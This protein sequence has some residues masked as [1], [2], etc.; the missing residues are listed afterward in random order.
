MTTSQTLPPPPPDDSPQR[1]D[2]LRDEALTLLESLA[3]DEWTDFN[4]HDPG[5]TILEALCYAITDLAY[6]ASFPIPD[7]LAR[8]GEPPP[9]TLFTPAQIL[10]THP[11]TLSDWRRLVI[12]M[13]GVKNAWVERTPSEIDLYYDDLDGG[14]IVTGGAQGLRPI[15]IQGLYRIVYERYENRVA[16]QV[17]EHVRER[18][19]AHRGLCEDFT[20][21]T[22]LTPQNIAVNVSVEIDAVDDPARVLADIYTALTREMSPAVPVHTLRERQQAEVPTDKI[23]EG[24]RPQNSFT[25]A[26]TVHTSTQ[27]ASVRVSDLVRAIMSVD[28]VRIVRTLRVGGLRDTEW[29][30][31][32]GENNV[33]RLDIAQSEIELVRAGVPVRLDPDTMT[34]AR[35]RYQAQIRESQPDS[36][37][38]MPLE[39]GRDRR[40]ATYRSIQHDLPDIYGLGG[41]P[42][43]TPPE[44]QAQM[45]QLQAYLLLF[46]LVLSSSQAQ[47]AH[48]RDLLDANDDPRTTFV[49]L[50]TDPNLLG[51]LTEDPADVLA[52]LPN[53]QTG[54]RNH[55]LDHMLAR[56]AEQ[57]TDYTLTS[58][59]ETS[60]TKADFLRQY[61]QIS[62]ARGSGYNYLQPA[63]GTNRSGLETRVA[64]KLGMQDIAWPFFVVEHILLRPMTGD[65]QQGVPLMTA[66]AWETD[67]QKLNPD[68]YSLQLSFIFR[69]SHFSDNSALQ[70]LAQRTVAEEAPAHILAFTKFLDDE[71]FE[72][73]RD[74]Y[75]DWLEKR[76]QFWQTEATDG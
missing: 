76:R 35:S 2:V 19:H 54:Q 59:T 52:A 33:P 62:S 48:L 36:P 1:Y 49:Q 17:D 45:H 53:N 34:A 75:F 23:F 72:A 42:A 12:D 43:S 57:L 71:A 21:I 26:E 4:A 40:L 68:P 73:L 25:D 74:A 31:P 69:A 70:T 24:P 22:A 9:A 47:V 37:V 7:L 41:L 63:S 60:R 14:K 61:P 44:R 18:V 55:L 29:D 38:D 3:G 5:I 30:L 6:R 15:Y 20:E 51:L 58:G 56:F 39:T 16:T 10:T 64:H 32:V 67:R 46:D 11:V 27:R 8:D 66:I 28:G 50:V 65:D 13:P